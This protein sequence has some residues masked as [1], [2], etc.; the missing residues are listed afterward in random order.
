MLHLLA[1][2][3]TQRG[4]ENSEMWTIHWK[5]IFTTIKVGSI[6]LEAVHTHKSQYAY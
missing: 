6:V 2:A 4:F 1:I 3:S 5:V